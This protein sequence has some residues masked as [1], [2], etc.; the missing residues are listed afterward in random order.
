MVLAL[1]VT[2]AATVVLFFAPDIP[3]GLATA[4]LAR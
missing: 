4:M 3:L 1:V 2:A